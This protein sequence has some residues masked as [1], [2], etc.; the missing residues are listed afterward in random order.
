MEVHH[1]PHHGHEKKIWK[2]YFWEFFMLFLAVFCGSLA[3]LQV[4]HYI[5]HTREKKYV[6]TLLEDLVNDTLDFK[7]DINYWNNIINNAD[8]VRFEIE[9][10]SA[11]RNH[12]LL[13]QSLVSL[14]YNNTFLYHDRTIQQLKSAGN[15]RLISNN[16]VADSIVA[17][18]AWVQ[19][20]INHIE[21]TFSNVL[22][23]EFQAMRNQLFN[24]KFYDIA[25]SDT[26]LSAAIQK[27]PAVF[28]VRQGK[29]EVLFQFYN[30]VNDYKWLTNTRVRILKRQLR[31]ARNLIAMLHK[32]YH[33]K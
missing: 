30:K 32:E 10:P 19:S 33:L 25:T 15:F 2:N 11:A 26:L 8:T 4:E 13:Y 23:P 7:N 1:H 24:S 14:N 17:Y 5:E 16:A 20:T 28:M 9:K 21:M 22:L 31:R 27:E 6:A 29:E 3:E 18:D 12:R